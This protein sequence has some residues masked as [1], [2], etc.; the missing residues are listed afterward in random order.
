MDGINSVKIRVSVGLFFFFYILHHLESLINIC[1]VLIIFINNYIVTW[2]PY[3]VHW[4]WNK[5]E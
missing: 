2:K 1:M 3:S 5:I 4:I